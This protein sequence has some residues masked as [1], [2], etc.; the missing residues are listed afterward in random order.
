MSSDIEAE[1][2]RSFA[3]NALDLFRFV[4]MALAVI[5][6]FGALRL[7]RSG[8]WAQG[9]AV[10]AGAML[11]ISGVIWP[12]YLIVLL[13]LVLAA[14]PSSSRPARVAISVGYFGLA[15]PLG[16]LPIIA[17]AIIIITL[18]RAPTPTRLL[19]VETAEGVELP[20]R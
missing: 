1:A 5:L 11:L 7:A 3:P 19:G 9:L 13:P 2:I 8:R 17:T 12:F 15:I 10:A 6:E 16:L 18:L 20:A 4:G 14:W